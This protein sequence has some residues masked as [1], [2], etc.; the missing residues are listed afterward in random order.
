MTW[1]KLCSLS[2]GAKNRLHQIKGF[3]PNQ[4]AFGVERSS[5]ESWLEK[6]DH[7]PTQSRRNHEITF[8]QNLQRIQSAKEAFLRADSRR[9][10]L[11]AEKGKARRV[12][13]FEVGQLVY[14]YR[15]GK[16]AASRN[17]AGWYG[18]ARVVGIEKQGNPDDNMSPGFHHLGQSWNHPVS[19]CTR[20]AEKSN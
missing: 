14:F 9:R 8:E 3:S 20:A 13:L 6:G 12:E 5:I 2:L 15:K 17:H 11:R 16:S 1:R 18:P 19:V 10:I 4:W 7:L